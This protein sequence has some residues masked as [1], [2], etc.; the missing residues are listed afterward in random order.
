MRILSPVD[1]AAEARSLVTLGAREL[2]GGL[3][4]ASEDWH[5][6]GYRRFI[7]MAKGMGVEGTKVEDCE[8][9]ARA[10][11]AGVATDGPYLIEVVL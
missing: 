5:I 6:D 3:R 11:E 7:S 1:N 8:S 4:L 2:Y 9:L 10:F